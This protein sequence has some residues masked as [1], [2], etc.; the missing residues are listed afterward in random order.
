M[1]GISDELLM[2]YEDGELAP[3]ERRMVEAALTRDPDT[4]RRLEVFRLTG[5]RLG[6]ALA[7]EL[8]R[9]VPQHLIGTIM[10]T[11]VANGARVAIPAGRRATARPDRGL[12]S[13]IW[14]AEGWPLPLVA[15]CALAL[16]AGVGL[17]WTLYGAHESGATTGL[18]AREG[19]RTEARGAL[20]AALDKTG[21]GTAVAAT[22]DGHDVAIKPV[23]SFV[24]RDR[25]LC[26]QYEVRSASGSSDSGLACR[27]AGGRWRVEVH[28]A[29]AGASPGADR[30]A[31]ASGPAA[32]GAIE[33]AIDRLIDGNVLTRAREDELILSGWQLR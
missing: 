13:W 10:T 5:R 32:A 20:A 8:E 15:A 6:E 2:R 29:A 16:A 30:I 9:P 1:S 33:A 12:L 28:N 7:A 3:A 24:A 4:V 11:P 23:L 26:R 27:Q 14:P 19:G 17:S 22:V 31:P 18:L 25:T 21:S